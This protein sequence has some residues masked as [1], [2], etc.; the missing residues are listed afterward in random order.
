MKSEKGITL[1]SLVIYVIVATIVI[2]SMAMLSTFFFSNMNLIKDQHEYAP[3]FNKFNM[4]FLEDIKI[5]KSAEVTDTTIT[6]E[7][8]TKYEYKA[9]E[10]AI[11][12]NDK[13]ITEKVE[14]VSFIKNEIAP[15]EGSTHNTTKQTIT[16]NLSIGEKNNFQKEIEYTL[17]YW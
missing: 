3:E 11:Y 1:T 9:A 8:G 6:F 16:V 17:K 15:S 10:K 4:F 5:N 2:S 7:D 14:S 12:R 13:K